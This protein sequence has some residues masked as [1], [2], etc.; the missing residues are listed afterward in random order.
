[1]SKLILSI[2]PGK[3]LTKAIALKDD[4]ELIDTDFLKNKRVFFRSKMYDLDDGD[5]ELQGKSYFTEYDGRKIIIGDQGNVDG[6]EET[7]KA[8]L[9]HKLCIYTAITQYIVPEEKTDV[10]MVLSCPLNLLKSKKYKDE[11]KEF[12]GN[13]GKEISISVNKENYIF[14]I[15]SITIKSEGSGILYLNKDKFINCEVA[16]ID[17]GGL[18][19]Q[20]CKYI[21]G[22]AVPESRFT[23]MTGGNKLVQ[24]IEEALEITLK[25]KP[26][27]FEQAEEAL[28]DK[29]LRINNSDVDESRNIIRNR[30]QRYIRNDIV[31]NITKRRNSLELMQPIVVG[32]TC[33]NIQEELKSVIEN[34]E[35]QEDPQWASVEGL[36]KIA[37]LKYGAKNGFEG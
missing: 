14:T 23:E 19:M 35:I 15:K 20:F 36:F 34:V 2:D 27:S 4:E 5:V 25:G 32:G 1:M 7:N 29:V 8:T 11:Y 6:A 33:L 37:Y 18:N 12:I 22:A 26:I 17:I 21:N 30:I 28:K 9:L 16:L 24:D 13:D 3:Y 10:Y 31:R